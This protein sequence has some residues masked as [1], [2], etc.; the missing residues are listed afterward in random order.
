MTKE[1]KQK[2]IGEI[3][4]NARTSKNLTQQKV[5]DDTGISR[6]YISDVENGRYMP[7]VETLL[8][9]AQYLKID[10]NLIPKMTEI[11]V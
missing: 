2:V 1:N 11:Q 4:K 3:I 8:T 10:L 9:L 6:N 5:S 7:S